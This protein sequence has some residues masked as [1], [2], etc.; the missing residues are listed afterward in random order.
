MA[1]GLVPARR[2]DLRRAARGAY[3]GLDRTASYKVKIV[4][5][6]DMFQVKVRLVGQRFD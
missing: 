6:G 3:N 1:T 2:H 4:Y 5:T